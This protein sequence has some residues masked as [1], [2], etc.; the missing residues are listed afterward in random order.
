[1]DFKVTILG[2]N[3]AIPTNLRNTSAQ[4]VQYNNEIFLVDCGEGTQT[5]LR[6]YRITFARINHIFISHLH[7]DHYFGIFGLLMSLSLMGRNQD[8]HIYSHKALKEMVKVNF[9]FSKGL[10][11]KIIYHDISN[12]KARKI[13]E[14]KNI[15]VHS[16]PLKH[17]MPTCG[18][19]FKEKEKE[20]LNIDPKMI[21]MYELKREDIIR[22]KKGED[23][24]D[25]DGKSVKN[26]RLTLPRKPLRSYAYCSDTAFVKKNT[27][28]L[29]GVSL[30]YHEAT[31]IDADI[32]RAKDTQHS[33]STQA[34][35]MAKLSNAGK[36]LIGHFSS[37]YTN[38]K[39]L[40]REAKTVFD[41]TIAVNDGDVY[42]INE[43]L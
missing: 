38:P 18:F 17:R 28:I 27:E 10:G 7:G 31:F 23:Y 33:T 32:K 26:E 22:I 24:I 6:K 3:S 15:E 16:F 37:R 42:E 12:L 29:Q 35:E 19:L 21:R 39:I 5:Q 34:A 13:L 43:R 25:E 14:L 2:S 30:M 9:Q 4:A 40:E 41:N 20:L 8:L 36:L 11:F 1:M